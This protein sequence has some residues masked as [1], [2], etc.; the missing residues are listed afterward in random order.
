MKKKLIKEIKKNAVLEKRIESLE[1]EVDRLRP[2]VSNLQNLTRIL[3]RDI[4]NCRDIATIGEAV[5]DSVLK[6]K[7]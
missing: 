4:C 7:E 2:A 1:A 6:A 3:E 5:K